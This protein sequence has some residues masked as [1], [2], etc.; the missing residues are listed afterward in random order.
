MVLKGNKTAVQLKSLFLGI[1]KNDQPTGSA[2]L[3][4]FFIKNLFKNTI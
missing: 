3:F 2:V 4:P 1:Q